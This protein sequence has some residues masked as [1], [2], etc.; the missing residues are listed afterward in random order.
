MPVLS[1]QHTYEFMSL[2]E[3]ISYMDSSSYK[4]NIGGEQNLPNDTSYVEGNSTVRFDSP[5]SLHSI[6]TNP[7]NGYQV[8]MYTRALEAVACVVRKV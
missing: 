4:I 2:L 6:A 7:K 8:P 3:A 1:V 5:T